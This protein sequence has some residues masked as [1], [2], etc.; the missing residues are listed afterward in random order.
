M[1]G[2]GHCMLVILDALSQFYVLHAGGFEISVDGG[3]K[4]LLLGML[5]LEDCGFVPF[6][7]VFLN[8]GLSSVKMLLR[9]L[10]LC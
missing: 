10:Y 3:H 4:G 9:L 8:V 5:L 6:L 2:F 1:F 7:H